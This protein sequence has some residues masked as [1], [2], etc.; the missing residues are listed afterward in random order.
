MPPRLDISLVGPENDEYE[1]I[2]AASR[3]LFPVISK[4][5]SEVGG[6]LHWSYGDS[7]AWRVIV[8]LKT[9]M[10][11]QSF[12][13]GSVSRNFVTNLVSALERSI[14]LDPD[15]R[16]FVEIDSD[17]RVN[18]EEG[19]FMRIKSDETAERTIVF[20]RKDSVAKQ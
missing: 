11:V 5:A 3:A 18:A 16:L 10:A 12:L 8:G 20:A 4:I 19:W 15:F 1:R 9:E 7:N 6:Q 17:E 13:E 14:A 2:E